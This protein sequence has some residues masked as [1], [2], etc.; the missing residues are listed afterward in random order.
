MVLSLKHFVPSLKV[1]KGGT[2]GSSSSSFLG[3]ARCCLQ[4]L[5]PLTGTGRVAHLPG[6]TACCSAN[7]SKTW[8]MGH[9][10]TNSIITCPKLCRHSLA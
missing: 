4:T 5:G 7:I 2:H 3:T 8:K 9:I 6:A 1:I 10:S